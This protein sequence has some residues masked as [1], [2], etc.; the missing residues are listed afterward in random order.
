PRSLHIGKESSMKSVHKKSAQQTLRRAAAGIGAA[1]AL[2]AWALPFDIA[3]ASAA[4]ILY[5][6]DWNPSTDGPNWIGANDCGG[7]PLSVAGPRAVSGPDPDP[8][9]GPED[10]N[11][12]NGGGNDNG[13]GDN[14]GNGDGN[15]GNGNG[16][17]GGNG[18]GNESNGNGPGDNSGNGDGNNG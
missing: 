13:P 15:N 7:G 8:Q 3:T 18:T 9:S 14:S 16:N 2:G 1:A 6:D 11:N 5:C 10:G 17:G 12:G 4:N